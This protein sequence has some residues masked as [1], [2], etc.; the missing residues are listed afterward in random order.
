MS[1]AHGNTLFNYHYTRALQ[2]AGWVDRLCLNGN[3]NS[4]ENRREF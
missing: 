3:E 1:D 4:E 2:E